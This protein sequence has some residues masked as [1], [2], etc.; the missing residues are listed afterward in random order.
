MRNEIRLLWRLVGYT[1][2]IIFVVI[3][4]TRRLLNVNR[5]ECGR[6][7]YAFNELLTMCL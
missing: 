5:S 7:G 2:D 1:P 6:L 4:E 3:P